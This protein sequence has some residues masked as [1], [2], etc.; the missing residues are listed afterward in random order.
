[1]RGEKGTFGAPKETT[2]AFSTRSR[3]RPHPLNAGGYGGSVVRREELVDVSL[4]D[5]R[6]PRSQVTD[7]QHF[8]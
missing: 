1:M 6:L 3:T 8:I 4:D 5:G 2:V 7:D